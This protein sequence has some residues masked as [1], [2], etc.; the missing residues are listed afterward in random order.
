M[1]IAFTQS[2]PAVTSTVLGPRTM[3][4]LTSLLDCCELTLD[5]ALLD[6]IDEITAPG[7]GLFPEWTWQPP[8]LAD[9]E[10]RRRTTGSRA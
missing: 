4:Q 10:L 3:D 6:R 2:H 5:K 1:A 9:P 8:A 7:T